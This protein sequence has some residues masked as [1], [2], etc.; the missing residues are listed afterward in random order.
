VLVGAGEGVDAVVVAAVREGGE[1]VEEGLGVAAADDPE[2]AVL[3]G[4]RDR[5]GTDV[6]AAGNL[7]FLWDFTSE[8]DHHTVIRLGEQQIWIEPALFGARERFAEV[9]ALLKVRYGDRFA[10][11]R[12]TERS[13]IWLYGD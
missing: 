1:L 11:L 6:L 7:L 13:E 9:E 5:L 4:G 3:G 8:Q 2:V 12:P 10:G